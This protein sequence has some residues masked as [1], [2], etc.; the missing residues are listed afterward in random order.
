MSTEQQVR[1]RKRKIVILGGGVGAM[2]AA[3]GLTNYPGWQDHYEVSLYSLGWRLGGKGASGRNKDVAQRI[4]EHGLHVWM[5][6]YENAFRVM[7]QAYRELG[8]PK[9]AP[10]AT[11]EEAF[12]KQ[13][14]IN[15]FERSATGW[16]N[17]DFPF[18]TNS[19]EPGTGTEDDL[20]TLVTYLERGLQ[21]LLDLLN[22][23]P[24]QGSRR[25]R[26]RPDSLP[27]R[28]EG[29]L[30][31]LG[32]SIFP[33]AGVPGIGRTLQLAQLL[34]ARLPRFPGEQDPGQIEALVWLV[35][36]VL[37]RL[38][39]RFTRSLEN[40]AVRK[41]WAVL[42][43]G[44]VV[45]RGVLKDGVLRTGFNAIDGEDFRAWLKRHGA[46]DYTVYRSPLVKG[47]YQLLF[48]YI[49][50]DPHRQQLAA[51]VA[52]RF[53]V[54][55]ALNY[56]G[57]VF[58]KM[59]AGMG[60]VVFTPLYEVL[61]RRGV[62]FH[63]F[64]KVNQLRVHAL[65]RNVDRVEMTQ[66][67][68]LKDPVAGYQPLVDVLGLPC[69]PDRPQLRSDRGWPGAG[70]VGDQPGVI[71]ARPWKGERPVTLERGRDYD[72][73]VMG[74]SL[75]AFPHL[76]A[77]VDCEQRA[78]AA[79]GRGAPDEP[80]AGRCRCGCRSRSRSWAGGQDPTVMTGYAEPLNTY[81]DMA[82]VIPRETWPPGTVK[83]IAY[84][85]APLVRRAGDP[86]VHGPRLPQAGARA[87]EAAV[88]AVA[89]GVDRGA[90]AEG[91]AATTPR[92]WTGSCWWT[93]AGRRAWRGS[94]AS[95]GG[96]TSIR[97]SGT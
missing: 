61:K 5:G 44:L 58:Y 46:S 42:E 95:T 51:G 80:D 29:V 48:A 50:G 82:Q 77:G 25:R 20:P 17:W 33:R 45:A 93:R 70:G 84:F 15:L 65:T 68:E 41:I 18:A 32:L 30:R 4:E 54:R 11:V 53:M 21:A 39:S 9:D 85:T 16:V 78:V 72:V 28:V 43:L 27:A 13:S 8:R 19:Q 34:A 81:A 35:E 74:I 86:S 90:V 88:G 69:W 55:M 91:D 92:R 47:M 71:W 79:D 97:A 40:S 14:L 64:H 76:A 60:D 66:Q 63:F 87:A 23:A 96:R 10:L 73:L 67:V 52:T 36:E 6:H 31:A 75:G 12:K 37:A 1:G 26:L 24:G 89:A 38:S 22:Q 94:T 59:R 49:Q 2:T 83:D 57:A 62:Q 3:F 56:K 7:R